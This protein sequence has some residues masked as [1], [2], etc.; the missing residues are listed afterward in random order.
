MKI[1][2]AVFAVVLLV[3]APVS[4]FAA[5]YKVDADHTS[6]TFKV[7]HLLSNTQGQFKKFE[8]MIDF[9]PGKPETW[10]AEGSIQVSSIDTGV[11]ER[12]KH[13]Q[14]KDF[15]EVEKYPTIT[16]KTGKVLESTAESARVEG[17]MTMHGVEK[18]ILLDVQ[19]L[20]VI[21]DPWGNT[22][23]AFTATTKINRKDFGLTYNQTLEAGGLMIGE[24]V[25]IT[26]EVE[27]IL[28]A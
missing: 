8:G 18:P 3:G 27:G 2:K 13:L 25:T 19:L 16:F 14:N 22:R 21:K 26:L 9:E 28:Q 7:R 12:D 4:V 1:W 17:L 23:S 6:V 10:K 20:G 15:F 5:T 24:D 11:A